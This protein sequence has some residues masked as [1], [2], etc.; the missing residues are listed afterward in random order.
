MPTRRKKRRSKAKRAKNS[1]RARRARSG[2]A[3]RRA[4]PASR[5]LTLAAL[6]ALTPAD[7]TVAL[8]TSSSRGFLGNSGI[9][10]S[11]T[12]DALLDAPGFE[13]SPTDSGSSNDQR[14]PPATSP[15]PPQPP[16]TPRR[17]FPGG[18]PA[19]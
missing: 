14:P 18:G 10:S 19:D 13:D 6:L 11:G 4:T 1:K 8:L 12:A 15:P 3:R 5:G 16:R 9:D 7:R 2:R 17:G